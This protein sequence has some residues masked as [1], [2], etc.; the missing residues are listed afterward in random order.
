MINT[1]INQR[2]K[3]PITQKC[4]QVSPLGKVFH[5]ITKAPVI[6]MQIGEI[7]RKRINAALR[8]SLFVGYV[9]CLPWPKRINGPGPAERL[10]ILRRI[11]SKYNR[12]TRR[13]NEWIIGAFG[14]ATEN[15]ETRSTRGKASDG[16]A[17]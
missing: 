16:V 8:R 13:D 10:K 15:V 17:Q 3:K 6:P 7:E 14:K 2:R 1:L 11:R 9:S 4:R 5:N 12:L